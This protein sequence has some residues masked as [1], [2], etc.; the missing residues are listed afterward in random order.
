MIV[1][2][3]CGETEGVRLWSFCRRSA[4]R[5]GKPKGFAAEVYWSEVDCGCAKDGVV[6][7]DGLWDCPLDVSD[8]QGG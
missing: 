7:T 6:F 4:D 3:V 1:A 8:M 2:V 5:N